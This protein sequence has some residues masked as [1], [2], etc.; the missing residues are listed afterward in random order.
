[1][2]ISRISAAPEDAISM[3]LRL[4]LRNTASR[5]LTYVPFSVV[6]PLRLVGKEGAR[7]PRL[8]PRWL[9]TRLLRYRPLESVHETFTISEDPLLL[10]TNDDSSFTR[11]LYWQG[12]AVGGASA[13]SWSILCSQATGILEIGGNVGYYAVVGGASAG[14]TPYTVVEPHP[15]SAEF[16][17]RNL[18]LNGLDH[19]AVIE[20][21]VV[22]RLAGPTVELF[23][24]AADPDGTPASA[25]L[26]ASEASQERKC[27]DSIFVAAVEAISLTHEG[28]DLIK[29]DVEG[30][31][32]EILRS[33]LPYVLEHRPRLFLEVLPRSSALRELI[34]TLCR[35]V[36]YTIHGVAANGF[37]PLSLETFLDISLVQAFSNQDVLLSPDLVQLR[38]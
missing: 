7:L 16:L 32:F 14:T 25:F 20:A 22:G 21:A 31:E 36:G 37:R 38:W 35:D 2:M 3:S 10:F 9:L 29:L 30:L 27:R 13:E 8:H 17:R 24:P 26:A 4:R 5:A 15:R 19:V 1:M 34:V 33:I 6:A 28:I 23:V 12:M 18:A 11:R